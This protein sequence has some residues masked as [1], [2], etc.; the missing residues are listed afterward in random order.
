M[1]LSG[2]SQ[3]EV[4]ERVAKGQTNKFEQKASKTW[5]AIVAGNVIDL[6]NAIIFTSVMFLLIYG[7]VNDAVLISG[8]I[9]VNTLVSIYQELRAKASLQKITVVQTLPVTVLR[10]G[11]EVEIDPSEI[12]KD[13]LVHLKAGNYLYVDGV[14]VTSE[15][16]LFDESI[17]TGESD[18]KTKTK[19]AEVFSGSAVIA[20][21]GYYRADKVGAE[22]FVNKITL[23][24]RKYINYLSPLQKDINKLVKL[25][26]I[27]TVFV[28]A[29]LLS[30]NVFVAEMDRI[31][32][33]SA[34][35][36]IVSSMV[37]QGIVITLT[38]A[39][40]L[41]VIRMYGRG[42][43]VQ[44][45][46][47]VETLAGVKVL[48]MDKTGT[49]TQNKLELKD[50]VPLAGEDSLGLV[51][52]FCRLSEDKNKTLL[53]IE[54]KLGTFAKP[55]ES[56]SR[57]NRSE[58]LAKLPFTSQQKCSG[59]EFTTAAGRR[60]RIILGAL[61][62]LG[63]S[64]EEKVLADLK[65]TDAKFAELGQRNLVFIYKELT[66]TEVG[67]HE[68]SETVALVKLSDWTS[69]YK[70]LAFVSIED[71]LRDGAKAIIEAFQEQ[72]IKP[73]I[74]SGD[75]A[76]T[77]QALIK[78]LKIEHLDKVITGAELAAINNS[79][80]FAES[81][82]GHDVFAR[83]TPEQKLE[84]VK[85]Y[86]QAF[87]YVAMVGDGVNDALAI[88]QANLGVSL[89]DGASVTKSIAD[90]IL[91]DNDF[92]KLADVMAEGKEILFNTLRSGQLLFV[93]NIY[94]LILIVATI[95]L[96]LPFPFNFRGLSIL[97]FINANLPIVM[98][99]LDR[100]LKLK[101]VDFMKDLLNFAFIGGVLAGVLSIMLLLSYR[102]AEELVLQN[103]ILAFFIGCGVVNSLIVLH[104]SFNLVKIFIGKFSFVP[105]LTVAIYWL[106][107]AITPFRDAFL[108]IPLS[109]EDWTIILAATFLYAILFSG[110]AN[111]LLSRNWYVQWLERLSAGVR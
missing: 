57:E 34:V 71:K 58:L 16:V 45:A 55:G 15:Q 35:V 39:F 68:G 90:V 12:V 13:D 106:M 81:V 25:L 100:N 86:Q 61:D 9:A 19:D 101:K 95:V 97:A 31:E 6:P 92:R 60:L 85:V 93:K 27:I 46:S 66:A 82:L 40:M 109:L 20:G 83:V 76:G 56:K 33:L 75:G 26:T 84:I 70:P 2:L 32:L 49:L 18:Y 73:V 94:S 36:S 11:K 54:A 102:S 5:L 17:L 63:E 41:G 14:I 69:S 52:E 53:A 72:D 23:E 107:L 96:V 88:K 22:S 29:L 1:Q 10:G 7:Q 78:K 104:K 47:A 44:K 64:L 89:A 21:S 50:F 67:Q 38:L 80:Q 65:Q 105:L 30:I 28:I 8:I 108:M 98:I 48:M 59:V 79:G 91:L 110:A 99:F 37:P 42:I 111:Y 87:G 3:A 74:I 43:L 51:E 4:S 77:L 103:V 62:I 24:A